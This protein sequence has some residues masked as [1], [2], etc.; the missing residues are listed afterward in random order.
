MQSRRYTL[1]INDNNTEIASIIQYLY[2]NDIFILPTV[3]VTKNHPRDIALLPAIFDYTTRELYEGLDE[4]IRFYEHHSGTMDV[5]TKSLEFKRKY[6]DFK[7]HSALASL[8]T[9]LEANVV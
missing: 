5:Y 4:C 6:P 9:L 8:R 3:V 1:Y 2:D 7:I